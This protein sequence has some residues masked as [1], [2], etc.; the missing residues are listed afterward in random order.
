MN[1]KIDSVNKI[2]IELNEI[3]IKRTFETC[4]NEKSKQIISNNTDIKVQKVNENKEQFLSPYSVKENKTRIV[5]TEISTNENSKVIDMNKCNELFIQEDFENGELENDEFRVNFQFMFNDKSQL[6]NP[7]ITNENL[8]QNQKIINKEKFDDELNTLSEKENNYNKDEKNV[9]KSFKLFNVFNKKRGRCKKGKSK[10]IARHTNS[11]F[12]D[13]YKKIINKSIES[14]VKK[15]NNIIKRKQLGNHLLNKITGI[16][17]NYNINVLNL[18]IKNILVN[19]RRV[20][21]KKEKKENLEIIKYIELDEE[22]KLILNM[23]FYE[24]IDTF[25]KDFDNISDK[26]EQNTWNFIL[27]NGIVNFCLQRKLRQKRKK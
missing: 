24:Y 12:D 27:K 13:C 21:T 18:N 1:H 3:Y 25:M 22:I 7:Y 23:K 17:K 15:V 2:S 14:A 16:E 11:S 26:K 20:I 8:N 10:S 4:K 6:S 19:Y 5:T 9:N